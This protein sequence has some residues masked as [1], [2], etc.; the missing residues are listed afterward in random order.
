[1]AISN[2]SQSQRYLKDR[3]Q[4]LLEIL[5]S[6]SYRE[7]TLEDYLHEITKSVSYLLMIDW[8]VVTCCDRKQESYQV[9]ASNLVI[10]SA[11]DPFVLHGS[12]TGTVVKTGK[13]LCIQDT[14]LENSCGDS[15]AGYRSYLG[16]P[17]KTPVGNVIGTVCCFGKEPREFS[18][19]ALQIA[20]L[21][22]ERAAIAIDNF[23]LYKQQQDFNQALEIEV[24]KRTAELKAAQ[25]KLIEKE[26]L[27]AIGQFAS[28]I[29]HEIRNPT[30]TILMGLTSLQQLKLDDRNQMRLN[31]AVEEAARL[32]ELLQEILLYAKPQIIKAE[33]I[34]LRQFLQDLAFALQEMPQAQQRHLK[35]VY[36]NEQCLVKG[37]R[38]K[39][40]QV[41]IN[42]VKNAFEA[43]EPGGTVT[44]K[45]SVANNPDGYCVSV[46]NGGLPIPPEI[47]P[48]LTEAFVSA[49]SGGTGLGL[50]IVKQIVTNHE[51]NLSIESN[52]TLGTKISFTLP[53]QK[54]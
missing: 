8:S 29:V 15:P 35:M 9:A 7:I 20:E 41:V 10:P 4:M 38:N 6:L 11:Q 3:A 48:R 1:M 21:F 25:A 46:L 45:L 5:S 34:E 33:T 39:L 47:L 12:V 42:L 17:L 32:Q 43:I 24:A 23:N 2:S 22:A 18:A 53:K 13:S 40:K 54:G 27:A 26:K 16:I 31:L 19:E 28:T 30:T 36:D 50:A 37:D 51:G 52:E 49:K 14:D 44:C